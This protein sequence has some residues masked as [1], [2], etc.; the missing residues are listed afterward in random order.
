MLI[1]TEVLRYSVPDGITVVAEVG[2]D[3]LAPAVILMHGGGQTR[4]SWGGAMQ[5]LL[6]RGYH[7]INLDARGHGDSDWSPS[8]D[9]RLDAL[10]RDLRTV[11][12]TL[13][14]PPA[15]VG[16]SLGGA[17]ALYASG[18]YAD[19]RP[20]ASMLVMV[21]VVPRAAPHGAA[22][23]AAFMRARP[24][25]FASL[26]EAANAVA[27]YYPSRQ[28]P[29][30]VSGLMKN[31]RLRADGR[32]HWHWDPQFVKPLRPD[33]DE[34]AE[35]LL[36]SARRVTVPTLLVRGLQSDI[37]SDA[38]IAEFR[39]ALPALEVLDVS[40]AGH[41]VAGDKND[42]FNEGVIAFLGRHRL[43]DTRRKYYV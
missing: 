41:M 13:S 34:F 33:M 30:D 3:P 35:L 2:G 18:N 36:K 4:H 37:V 6:R 1:K 10:S 16:A 7:V 15:L 20:V 21:D 17:T 14:S 38:G 12:E 32:L 23:I 26:Q 28:R 11:V 29:S 42:A 25:G 8:A 27:A 5:Q 43:L 9:Y 22:K 40:G 39:E 24:D 31:L 19:A